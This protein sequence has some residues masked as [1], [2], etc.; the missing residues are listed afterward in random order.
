MP[1][2][3]LLTLT[4]QESGQMELSDDIGSIGPEYVGSV[5]LPCLFAILSVQVYIYYLAA[6]ARDGRIIKAVVYGL[7]V[8]LTAQMIW[9]GL[10]GYN[11]FVSRRASYIWLDWLFI[12]IVGGV[13]GLT[14]QV[15]YAWRIFVLSR[16]RVGP[17]ALVALG[18]ISCAAAITSGMFG[19]KAGSLDNLRNSR[20]LTIADAIKCATSALCDILIA[21]YMTYLLTRDGFLIEDLKHTIVKIVRLTIETNA[22]TAT[23]AV[24]ILI[25]LLG[26]KDQNYF[27]VFSLILPSLYGNTLLI[28]MNSRI[29]LSYG[30]ESQNVIS[31]SGGASIESIQNHGCG[32]CGR[33][34]ATARPSGITGL[35]PLR[36]SRSSQDDGQ[37]SAVGPKNVHNDDFEY[38]MHDLRPGTAI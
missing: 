28:M 24:I 5:V 18:L 7:Y 10:K 27:T 37:Q 19:A 8:V 3:P 31:V 12:P 16:S 32:H 15:L 4:S 6:A 30:S 38:V 13:V 25:L 21:T 14:V 9:Q 23:I 2:I 20:G 36:A 29:R 17:L 1:I 22:L 11:E 26:T 34:F 35:S 33:R